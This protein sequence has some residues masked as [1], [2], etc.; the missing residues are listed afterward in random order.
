MTEKDLV[1]KLLIKGGFSPFGDKYEDGSGRGIGPVM[2]QWRLF[3]QYR[4]R[5]A[6]VRHPLGG[7]SWYHV[8]SYDWQHIKPAMQRHGDHPP[9]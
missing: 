7:E 4:R 8:A 6:A 1:V 5:P 3:Y 9:F 2:G